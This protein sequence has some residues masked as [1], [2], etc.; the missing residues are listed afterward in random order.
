MENWKPWKTDG[1]FSIEMPDFC[2]RRFALSLT[3]NRNGVFFDIRKP[4]II[5]YSK[6][7]ELYHLQ[8][9]Q[10]RL[11]TIKK[12][13]KLFTVLFFEKMPC[14]FIPSWDVTKLGLQGHLLIPLVLSVVKSSPKTFEN[15]PVFCFFTGLDISPEGA[16]FTDED[17]HEGIAINKDLF[18]L[19]IQDRMNFCAS[20]WLIFCTK[21]HR[22]FWSRGIFYPMILQSIQPSRIDKFSCWWTIWI[23]HPI[24]PTCLSLVTL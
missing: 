6:N 22:Q 13:M 10:R 17:V 5:N 4:S 18:L 1:N 8:Y 24:A 15:P 14:T 19:V 16:L 21:N 12:M 9:T 7:M 11:V 23:F 2:G 20:E 3:L